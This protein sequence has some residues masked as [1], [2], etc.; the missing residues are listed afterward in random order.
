MMFKKQL[1]P[2]LG[3]LN[4]A[5][6]GTHPRVTKEDRA[7][8]AQDASLGP[9]L[10]SVLPSTHPELNKLLEAYVATIPLG[11][12]RSLLAIIHHALTSER[13]VL[14]NFAWAPAYDHEI[15]VWHAPDTADT[16]GGITVLIKSRYPDDKHPIA[17]AKPKAKAKA[18]E[19]EAKETLWRTGKIDA[20]RV[21]NLSAPDSNEGFHP[22]AE[23]ERRTHR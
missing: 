10:A 14:L 18:K 17:P 2:V 15:T 20:I 8:F 7:R 1:L 23:F 12:Q 6:G 3:A 4:A 19:A 21:I 11:I 5:F 9:A 13:Q 22:G 16:K